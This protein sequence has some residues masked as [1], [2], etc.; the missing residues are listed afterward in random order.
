VEVA[1]EQQLML[2]PIKVLVDLAVEEMEPLLV[3]LL[4][5]MEQQIQVLL[6]VELLTRVLVQEIMVEQVAQ[7]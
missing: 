5:E 4:V 1:V 7:A 2:S 3:E 6:V